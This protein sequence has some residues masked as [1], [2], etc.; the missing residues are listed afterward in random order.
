MVDETMSEQQKKRTMEALE[1][2][3]TQ[4]KAEIHQQQ[5]KNKKIGV[6]T[7]KTLAENNIGLTSQRI[8]SL[9]SLLKS[10]TPSSAPSSKKDENEDV[11]TTLPLADSDMLDEDDHEVLDTP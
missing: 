6:T 1:R 2:R 4:A 7:T 10:T 8:N 9:P 5:H 11:K 3:F